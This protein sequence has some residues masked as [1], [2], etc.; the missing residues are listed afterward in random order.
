MIRWLSAGVLWAS[1]FFWV[2]S[3]CPIRA[4]WPT[5][6]A[7]GGVVMTRSVLASL[8]AG[9]LSGVLLLKRGDLLSVPPSFLMDHLVPSLQSSWNICVIL[10][11]L[12][13]GGFVGLIE[14]GG[15]LG[16]IVHRVFTRFQDKRQGLQWAAFCLGFVCFFD[17]LANSMFVGRVT[18]GLARRV[19]L[20]PEKLAYIVDTTSSPLACL[21]VVSTWI[22]Y[23]LS[24][25]QE[26]YAQAGREVESYELFF[27]SIPYNFYCWFSLAL[28]AAVLFWRRD[29]GG[30]RKAEAAANAEKRLDTDEDGRGRTVHWI[31]AL[32]PLAFLWIAILGG[33][34]WDGSGDAFSPF[35]W[36]KL[37][38]AVGKA[39]TA[40]VLVLA[41][42]FSCGIAWLATIRSGRI[43]ETNAAW[44]EGCRRLA[45][46]VFILIGAWCLSS[47]LKALGAAEVLTGLLGGTLDARLL[48]AVVF[49]LGVAISFSTGTSWGTMGVLMPLA[50]PVG[51]EC[52]PEAQWMMPAVVGAVFSGAVFGDHC[53]PI[54][55]T[56]IVS[57][58]ASDCGTLEHVK[59]QLPYA[60]LAG[61]AALFL[62]FV[63]VGWGLNVWIA[64][65]LGGFV[66]AVAPRFG[67]GSS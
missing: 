47:T 43:V 24:M 6:V 48:P 10:F 65:G 54:S 66:M 55:D 25:I 45:A 5:V 29:F 53:S 18:Q 1:T 20:S 39:D 26:G 67:S 16:G 52:A 7:L 15:G 34:Y 49:L 22:A 63:A 57:S 62:G 59:T 56:T 27:R 31:W 37:R 2:V 9:A 32:G 23:Q 51:L 13:M 60:F 17:G 33:L 35:S 12:L 19:G 28:L 64:L 61:V 21:A 38:E 46:P 50:I 4:L 14:Y 40:K 36:V 3:D 41:S 11:T 30:M 58:I 44:L 42:A 8:L